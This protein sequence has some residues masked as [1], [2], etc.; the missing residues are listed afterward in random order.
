MELRN[1]WFGQN[2][3]YYLKVFYGLAGI[4]YAM[5]VMFDITNGSIGKFSAFAR[6]LIFYSPLILISI[7]NKIAKVKG[8]KLIEEQT[9]ER[10]IY[11]DKVIMLA[12]NNI[13]G[14]LGFTESYL[15][16]ISKKGE[17]CLIIKRETI[18]T[19]GIDSQS[20]GSYGIY[21]MGDNFVAVENR[22]PIFYCEGV[23]SQEEEYG[24]VWTIS[25]NYWLGHHVSS[26]K[27][28]KK[29]MKNWNFRRQTINAVI[30]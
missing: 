3:R 27:F 10:V 21:D 22:L 26:R 13:K 8:K 12:Q 19:V 9:G 18:E 14:T 17:D 7:M 16:F 4:L 6:I 30:D 15:A 29:I 25:P 28:Y 20:M 5:A 23:N 2:V 24:F 1:P 11:S